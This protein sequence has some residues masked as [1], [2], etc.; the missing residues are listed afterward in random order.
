MS[1]ESEYHAT[2]LRELRST[3]AD[4]EAFIR[5]IKEELESVLSLIFLPTCQSVVAQINAV[6]Y[7]MMPDDTRTSQD[8]L[9]VGYVRAPS[10][11]REIRALVF[12]LMTTV[13]T[14]EEGAVPLP[15][16]PDGEERIEI[17]DVS[18]DALAHLRG[19]G[20]EVREVQ[21]R[22]ERAA[23]SRWLLNIKPTWD[24][25]VNRLQS[26]G[27]NF[28]SVY[29]DEECSLDIR[30][31]ELRIHI[32]LSAIVAAIAAAEYAPRTGVP[33]VPHC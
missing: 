17:E 19:T 30:D 11:P 8:R 29:L 31:W 20:A 7:G 27:Y 9:C 18:P 32:G 15:T 23:E 26:I 21:R 14:V 16:T 28:Q 1:F 24:G 5:G 33:P 6:G 22:M 2:K 4:D 25:F 10:E 13:V 12:E 3:N